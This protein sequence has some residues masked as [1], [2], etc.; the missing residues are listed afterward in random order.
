MHP[1]RASSFVATRLFPRYRSGR[2]F[3]FRED[4]LD[5]PLMDFLGV[6]H[7]LGKPHGRMP[8]PWESV[9][10]TPSGRI[11]HNGDAMTL[12]HLAARV[13]RVATPEAALA[14]A[15]ANDDL[16]TAVA[17]VGAE[18]AVPAGPQQG[19]V[20]AVRP[21]SNGFDLE[22]AAPAGGVVTSSVS[23]APG[24]RARAGGRELPVVL[25]NSGF[26]GVVVPAGA[27]SVQ[28]DYRPRG[29]TWGLAA[30]AATLLGLG[31]AGLAAWRRRAA[32]AV[33]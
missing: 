31:V 13:D 15:L 23:W 10:L 3:Q 1:V 19:R 6:A 22:L 29:W 2:H 24:W 4:R 16:R 32:E 21:R 7:V 33:P 9:H 30:C 28:L 17:V 18:G 25:A 20:T 26:V 5:Q 14:H 27:A 12:F 8:P 11:W